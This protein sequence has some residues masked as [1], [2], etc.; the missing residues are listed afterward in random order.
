MG[1]LKNLRCLCCDSLSGARHEL[2]MVTSPTKNTC[3]IVEFVGSY[4]T[5]FRISSVQ[6]VPSVKSLICLACIPNQYPS[7]AYGKWVR[8]VF[9][10]GIYPSWIKSPGRDFA[11]F[12]LMSNVRCNKSFFGSV[13]LALLRPFTF[14]DKVFVFYPLITCVLPRPIKNLPHFA[15]LAHLIECYWYKGLM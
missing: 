11:S 6:S 5:S 2:Y 13:V 12:L 3:N 4:G 14:T 7:V 9:L 15:Y 8:V 10:A 1:L